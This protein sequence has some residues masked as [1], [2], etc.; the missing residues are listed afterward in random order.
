MFTFKHAI[1]RSL[2]TLLL[3]FSIAIGTTHG[4]SL[5]EMKT[6]LSQN[7]YYRLK[8][9][10]NT[11]VI[12]AGGTT[13][14]IS[15]TGDLTNAWNSIWKIVQNGDGYT[16]QNVWT[17]KYLNNAASNDTPLATTDAAMKYYLRPSSF[18]HSN[19]YVVLS[20]TAEF[21]GLTVMHADRYGN[22]VRWHANT[23]TTENN[24]SDWILEPISSIDQTA[25]E[26]YRSAIKPEAGAY[27]YIRNKHYPTRRMQSPATM[28]AAIAEQEDATEYR[29]LWFVEATGDGQYAFKNVVTGMYLQNNAGRSAD[30]VM[31][32]TASP[33]KLVFSTGTAPWSFSAKGT[34]LA[35]HAAQTQSYH[36]VG[37]DANAEASQ[38]YLE[39]SS[40]TAAEIQAVQEAMQRFRNLDNNRAQYT[41]LLAKFFDDAACTQLKTAFK[42][43]SDNALK[44]AMQADGLPEILQEMAVRVKNDKWNANNTLAN[45]YEKSFRIAIY[46]PQSDPVKWANDQKL[47]R[48]SFRY[49]QLTTPSGITADK[50]NVVCLFV[51]QNAPAGTTLEAEL[52]YNIDRTGRRFT[53]KQGVNFL[54]AERQEHIY[55]RYNVDN[56]D[57]LLADLPK[58]KVHIENGRA[59][60]YFDT[61]RHKQK[62]WDEMQSLKSEGFMQDRVWRM[63]SKRYTYIFSLEEVEKSR[64]KGEWHYHGNDMGLEGVLG[65]W[66]EICD[67]QLDFLSVER[68]ADR[69]N[70]VLLSLPESGGGLYATTYGIYGI[71]VL[72]YTL[73]AENYENSEGAGIWGLAHE[74][75]HHF[76]QLYDMRGTLESSNNLFSIVAMWKTGTN[77]SRG[78]SLPSLIRNTVNAGNSWMDLGISERMRLYWQLYLYYVELGHKPTFFKELMDKFRD[79]PMVGGEA[80]TDFLRFAKFASDV[81]QEDLTDFFEFYGFF[82][83]T[84]EHI[85]IKWGD[86]FY[87]T[88]YAKIYTNVRQEDI[89]EAKAYMAKYATKRNNLFFIDERV[90][91]SEAKNE[92]MLPGASRYGT[93]STATPGDVNEMGDG[94][95]FTDYLNPQPAQPISVQV[96]DRTFSMVGEHVMGYKVYDATGALVFVSNKNVFDLPS[97]INLATAKIVAAG[98]D[99][100]DVMVYNNG[101]IVAQYD[102]LVVS[103]E[104][105]NTAGLALSVNVSQPEYTYNI[106]VTPNPASYVGANT[107]VASSEATRGKFAFFPGTGVGTYYI[108]STTTGKWLGYSDANAG[109]DRITLNDTQG[110]ASQWRVERENPT[111][112]SFDISPIFSDLGWNWHGGVNKASRKSMG[113]YSKTDNHSSWT[114]VPTDV[115]T[116]YTTAANKADLLLQQQGVGYPTAT[117]N[118]RNELKKQ[119]AQLQTAYRTWTIASDPTAKA[120]ALSAINTVILQLSTAAASFINERTDITMPENGKIYRIKSAMN[121]YAMTLHRMPDNAAEHNV[122]MAPCLDARS[123]WVCQTNA[124]GTFYLAALKGNGT[125]NITTTA[126][127]ATLADNGANLNA[128]RGN[129]FGTLYLRSGGHT[130]MRTTAATY[131]QTTTDVQTNATATD[132]SSDFYFEEVTDSAFTLNIRS[133]SN[134][135]LASVHLPYAVELPA[136][137]KVYA[138]TPKDDKLRLDEREPVVGMSGERILPAYTPVLLSAPTDGNIALHPA[139]SSTASISTGMLGTIS[140]VSNSNLQLSTYHYYALTQRSGAFVMR[141]IGKANLP[142]NKA[143]YR[144]SVAITPAPPTSLDLVFD[145][146]TTGID[147]PKTKQM[148][149]RAYDLKGRPVGNTNARGVLIIDGKKVVKH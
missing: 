48:T 78:M 34:S 50:G 63:K 86:P 83:K 96:N 71:G 141:L 25:M 113:L 147:S 42:N 108:L 52:A 109:D 66:D 77:V 122:T 89:D 43:L 136:D 142:A 19:N 130:F 145:E 115:T 44:S 30:F 8:S 46:D 37:W 68:Y 92:Y 138:V 56:T 12:D 58:I 121:D 120:N 41:T 59:N 75:G 81:A 53:L 4:E 132:K 9:H 110:Q 74:T 47:M 38:W 98:A 60:G 139:P 18:T 137:V 99:G 13:A 40:V 7:T 35:L 107:V 5:Q 23:S 124:D 103:P 133:G 97:T 114:F 148:S 146:K 100:K 36:V 16:L 93:S 131:L 80:K 112:N 3:L 33:F 126:S 119:L 90:R 1:G 28:T 11:Y 55:I 22:V 70:C 105:S 24:A 104:F 27:Y 102:K 84:G 128:A 26:T 73:L 88:N 45:T 69:F 67:Q 72:N 49:S 134:G 64:S 15:A 65:K 10:Y 79:V 125:L 123:Y 62:A 106:Y 101:A 6:R 57:L 76:Q 39:K 51:D 116:E 135:N 87:D 94:G 143:Y 17:G 129:R 117:S 32:T 20:W 54:Y 149:G 85:N 127:G 82:R 144:S 29:Q 14:T 140:A 111:V 95:H 118:V 2:G 61:A 21:S 31:G 91:K